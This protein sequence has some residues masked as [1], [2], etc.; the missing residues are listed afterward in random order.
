MPGTSTTTIWVSSGLFWT[1]TWKTTD[2]GNGNTCSQWQFRNIMFANP[3]V[4]IKDL[5]IEPQG[6]LTS[7]TCAP[8]WPQGLLDAVCQPGQFYIADDLPLDKASIAG[9]QAGAASMCT[10]GSFALDNPFA[11]PM[12][13]LPGANMAAIFAALTTTTCADAFCVGGGDGNWKDQIPYCQ[14][15]CNIQN[16]LRETMMAVQAT[17]CFFVVFAFVASIVVTL[18]KC[19]GNRATGSLTAAAV[20]GVLGL[21]CAFCTMV[22]FLGSCPCPE[23]ADPAYTEKYDP[24]DLGKAFCNLDSDPNNLR[25]LASL[26]NPNSPWGSTGDSNQS[27]NVYT[28][29]GGAGL[30]L[31]FIA[32]LLQ[33]LNV[34]LMCRCVPAP[35]EAAG[36]G[37]P[38]L[39]N[40]SGYGSSAGNGRQQAPASGYNDNYRRNDRGGGNNRGG[41][42]RANYGATQQ[43]NDENW[44]HRNGEWRERG[45]APKAQQPRYPTADPDDVRASDRQHNARAQRGYVDVP[46]GPPALPRGWTAVASRSRPG[47]FTYVNDYT[48]ER[49]SWA[50]TKAASRTKGKLPRPPK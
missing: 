35:D 12:E 44:E 40:G 20:I 30:T 33:V 3:H 39:G 46:A 49:I 47:Q 5:H 29:H 32:W 16:I 14:N 18:H 26:T 50:P 34:V 15:I 23:L 1:C 24:I 25:C 7:A 42:N 21:L 36:R 48:G 2:Y 6:D 27:S 37:D 45:S 4:T 38:L 19:K 10:S 22:A 43:D 11:L 9:W 31:F 17:A 8:N 41:N 28:R 13:V